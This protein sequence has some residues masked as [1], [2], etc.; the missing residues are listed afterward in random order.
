M[1]F[2]AEDLQAPQFESMSATLG[3]M[4]QPYYFWTGVKDN[5]L[6]KLLAQ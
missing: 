3:Q 6:D 1:S 5:I 2:P 4:W